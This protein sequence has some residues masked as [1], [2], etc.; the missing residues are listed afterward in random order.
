[1]TRKSDETLQSLQWCAKTFSWS[2][3]QYGSKWPVH[4]GDYSRRL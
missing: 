1:M 4:T 3:S 2:L